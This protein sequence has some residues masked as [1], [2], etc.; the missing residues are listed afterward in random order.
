MYIH[1]LRAA[2]ALH[3]SSSPVVDLDYCTV[4]PARFHLLNV[5]HTSQKGGPGLAVSGDL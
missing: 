4:K 2:R 5:T 1:A 3:P